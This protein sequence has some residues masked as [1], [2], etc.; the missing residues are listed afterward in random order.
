MRT[1][2]TLVLA[3]AIAA[4]GAS[5]AQAKPSA[6]SPHAHSS[7]Q[8]DM[9]ASVAIAAAKARQQQDLRS[10]DARDAQLHPRG[11]GA[12]APDAVRDAAPATQANAQ[13]VASA[14]KPA[15]VHSDGGVDW[16]PI[17]IA[18]GASLLALAAIAALTG[19]RTR[20]RTASA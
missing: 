5:G 7:A 17:L 3:L 9:H 18:V 2:R 16:T 4:L 15:P 13:P 10:P 6:E 19:R 20:T 11:V 14:G 12:V 8:Q 1:L